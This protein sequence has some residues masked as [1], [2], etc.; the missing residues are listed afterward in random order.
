MC[1]PWKRG[2]SLI[3]YISSAGAALIKA[4]LQYFSKFYLFPSIQSSDTIFMRRFPN[5]RKYTLGP[6]LVG[7][8]GGVTFQNGPPVDPRQRLSCFQPLRGEPC[9]QAWELHQESLA[10]SAGHAGGRE[11]IFCQER[12]HVWVAR[13]KY[14]VESWKW[15]VF[16]KGYFKTLALPSVVRGSALKLFR[17][18]FALPA[19]VA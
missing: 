7:D 18:C 4:A 8:G 2:M 16:I 5:L 15:G 1:C 17:L 14:R 19:A 6:V 13:G 10:E 12:T 3:V 11:P 9:T